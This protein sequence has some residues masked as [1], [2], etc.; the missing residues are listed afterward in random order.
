MSSNSLEKL[1]MKF[2]SLEELNEYFLENTKSD[3]FNSVKNVVPGE[4]NP[5]ADIMFVG[6]APGASEDE[7]GKP[8][9]GRAGKFLD[10][11]LESIDLDRKDVFIT[12]IV[13]CRPPDNRDPSEEEKMIF[14]P[15]LEA[16]I[17]YINPKIFVPL[18]RHAL[19]NFVP[20][21][22]IS[23]AHGHIYDSDKYKK[24]VFAM[25]HPA[26][27]LY[28]GSYKEVLLEDIKNLKRYLKSL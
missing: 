14:S 2:N 17:E 21:L 12:N 8:F 6:E 24:A 5:N 26:V 18:G 15:W 11:L 27:A 16:Q 7:S 23:E 3:L 19:W 20:D 4:G 13:K 1:E 9:V 28:K 25:Y 22:K 10:I